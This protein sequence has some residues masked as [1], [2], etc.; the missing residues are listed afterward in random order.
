MN[1]ADLELKLNL[2]LISLYTKMMIKEKASIL[3]ER[4]DPNQKPAAEKCTSVSG[5]VMGSYRIMQGTS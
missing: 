4:V 1:P 5:P 3:G 2:S